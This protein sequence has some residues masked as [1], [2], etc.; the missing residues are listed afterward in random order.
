MKIFGDDPL[1]LG[2]V[3]VRPSCA[4][5]KRGVGA[6]NGQSVHIGGSQY[7]SMTRQ[8]RSGRQVFGEDTRG[9]CGQENPRQRRV[10]IHEVDYQTGLVVD[11]FCSFPR[12][13]V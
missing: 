11:L 6:Q 3:G 12:F 10:K 1:S 8:S 5:E 9:F 2:F 4:L 13:T 7:P